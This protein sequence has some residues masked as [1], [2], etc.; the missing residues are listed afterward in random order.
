MCI[1]TYIKDINVC[2][3]IQTYHQGKCEDQD[4]PCFDFNFFHS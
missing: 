3:H 2:I 4:C 1:N